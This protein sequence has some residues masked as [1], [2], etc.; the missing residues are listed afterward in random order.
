MFKVNIL[1]SY[2]ESIKCY[3]D[4]FRIAVIHEEEMHLNYNEILEAY[5]IHSSYFLVVDAQGKHFYPLYVYSA[6]VG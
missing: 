5:G 6:V 3:D 1:D 4:C 2:G